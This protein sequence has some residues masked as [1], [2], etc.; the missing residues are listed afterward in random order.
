MN[1]KQA[2]IVQ[3]GGRWLRV[4]TLTLTMVGPVVNMLL[5][6]LRQRSLSLREQA[7]EMQAQALSR[8]GA[9]R[10]RLDDFTAATR[11]GALEQA[12]QLQKQAGQL[13]SQARQ[14]RKA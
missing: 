13:R 2:K 5:E 10:E 9:A 14:L 11:K 7:E 12:K 3:K 1:A 6:R 4:A 8:Q